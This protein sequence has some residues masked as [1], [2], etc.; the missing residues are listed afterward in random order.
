MSNRGFHC[1]VA[2][3]CVA[4]CIVLMIA[5]MP[6]AAQ[7][8]WRLDG[9]K[10]TPVAPPEPGTPEA[11]IADARRLYVEGDY[12]RS[13]S[14]LKSWL[15]KHPYAPQ[16]DMALL[17][18]ADCQYKQRDY[19]KAYETLEKLANNFTGGRAY[20]LA[21]GR[22]FKISLLFL[23]GLR[24]KWLGMRILSM[25]QEA[26]QL[27]DR[28][29]DREEGSLLAEK[30]L[31][32]TANHYYA[33]AEFFDAEYR[34]ALYLQLYPN[35]NA[36]REALWRL[37]WCYQ[38]LYRGTKYDTSALA[39]ARETFKRYKQRYPETA[40]AKQVPD[41]LVRARWAEAKKA[42]EVGLY[43]LRVGQKNAAAYYFRSV[44]AEY[45]TTEWA[46]KSRS[47]LEKLGHA[48]A[49]SGQ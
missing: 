20:R 45:A 33:K 5:A 17:F 40:Q 44:I 48:P 18:L 31:L 24:R 38:G 12:R 37:A 36:V 23:N 46:P 25:D 34:Y 26:V 6:A 49:K 8:T 3:M 41:L 35:G 27:L 14:I 9:E 21:L 47:E 22:Q 15:K 39:K 4:G 10:L 2:A 28:I 43:Y 16:S 19:W 32:A 11:I 30:C 7:T 1:G 13:R 29:R 42:Y